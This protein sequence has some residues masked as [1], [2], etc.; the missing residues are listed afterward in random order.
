M[1]LE[2]QNLKGLQATSLDLHILVKLAKSGAGGREK[3][4]EKI[5]GLT[6]QYY[7][8]PGCFLQECQK[9]RVA[10]DAVRKNVKIGVLRIA[11]NGL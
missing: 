7:P 9:K 5:F 8:P 3:F 2:V 1:N 6:Y 10:R 4:P 11:K